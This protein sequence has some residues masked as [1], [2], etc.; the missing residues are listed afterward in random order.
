VQADRKKRNRI[1]KRRLSPH[2]RLL[3]KATPSGVA[4]SVL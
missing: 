1:L 4:F 2:F 3:K